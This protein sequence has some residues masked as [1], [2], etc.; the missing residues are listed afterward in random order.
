MKWTVLYFDDQVVN[1]EVYRELLEDNFEVIGTHDAREYDKLLNEHQ[2]HAIMLDVHMPIMDGHLLYEKI[3]S[4]PRYNDCP[5][6]F[7]SGDIS[8]ENK[9]RSYQSGAV[10]FISREVRSE[11]LII[12]L[13]NKIKLY[14]Q[15][16]TKLGLGNLN[17]DAESLELAIG[18]EVQSVTM[19]EMRI[20]GVLLRSWPEVLSR[21]GLIKKIWGEESVKPGTI[22]THITNLRPKIEK[23]DHTIK[24]RDDQVIIQKKED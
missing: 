14:Q 20:L 8:D 15:M 11:E 7:I 23:W 5:I 9:V 24:I 6:F 17:L 22:N 2:P 3:V 18:D 13:K 19:L 10:D 21:A 16:T 1:I 4:H 12:R